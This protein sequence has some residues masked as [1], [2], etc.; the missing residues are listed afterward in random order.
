[1]E[2]TVIEAKFK[3]NIFA[4]VLI[5]T[6]ITSIV[7]GFI[8]A[9]NVYNT[10]GVVKNQYFYGN[11]IDSYTKSYTQIYESFFD[12]L[13]NAFMFHMDFQLFVGII[14]FGILLLV[15]ALIVIWDMN[16][17]ALTVTDRRVTGKASFGKVVDLPLNQISAIALG[18]FSRIS[19]S[20]S[21]GRVHFWW[22]ANRNEVY[23]AMTELIGNLQ[24]HVTTEQSKVA[25]NTINI[26]EELKNYKEL[27]DT[28]VITQDEF[29][30]KKKQLLGL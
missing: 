15:I 24:T 22:I 30:A 2:K 11:Y 5:L 12:F 23:K 20:T 28:G 4:G 1:M 25:P 27:L 29:D 10:E 8:V 7:V 17:C 19:V 21:S 14:F 6:A 13:Y 18:Y 3:K 9:Y 26:T 16:N